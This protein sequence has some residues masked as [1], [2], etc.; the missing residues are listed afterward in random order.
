MTGPRAPAEEVGEVGGA[1]TRCGAGWATGR[2]ASGTRGRGKGEGEESGGAGSLRR[3]AGSTSRTITR[4][5]SSSLTERKECQMKG[6][7]TRLAEA[8]LC[9]GW[10]EGSTEE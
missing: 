4:Y 7:E 1:T 10:D 6:T 8:V 2:S 5:T 3:G 9:R